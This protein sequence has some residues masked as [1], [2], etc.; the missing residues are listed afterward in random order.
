MPCSGWSL[1]SPGWPRSS[2]GLLGQA[3]A[4]DLPGEVGVRSVPQW[5]ART[6]R[7]TRGQ[8]NRH[9]ALAAA[10]DSHDQT[11]VA[12]A[13]GAVSAEQALVITAAVDALDDDLAPERDRAEA[14]LIAQ[15]AD[16]DAHALRT[17]GERL[18]EVIDPATA[19]E[20]EAKALAAQEERARAKTQ[21]RMGHAGDGMVRGSFTIPALQAEMFRKAL[22]ALAAP[23]HVRATEGAGPTTTTSPPRRSSG[24]RSW[25]TSSGTRP[26]SCR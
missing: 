18:F 5:L 7:M 25:S 6:T 12:V 20:R 1:I 16:H 17:M 21:L 24:T 9:T 14:F 3:A 19:E 23:K 10:L 8:A 11:R 13:A 26:V 15:A 2:H 4:L 22:H